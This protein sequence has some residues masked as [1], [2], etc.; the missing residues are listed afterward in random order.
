MNAA[1]LTILLAA[2]PAAAQEA[3]GAAVAEQTL[4]SVHALVMRSSKEALAWSPRAKLYSILG[5]GPKEGVLFEEWTVVYGDPGAKDGFFA[6]KFGDGIMQERHVCRGDH[7][8]REFYW[9]G[10]LRNR[11]E[12]SPVGPEPYTT[13]LPLGSDFM[14]A[15]RL[16]SLLKARKFSRPKGERWSLELSRLTEPK[17]S[18]EFEERFN[19]GFLL[20]GTFRAIGPIPANGRDRIM[21]IVDNQDEAVFL[22]AATGRLINR[23]PTVNKTGGR[24]AW[25]VK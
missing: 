11:L 25:Q 10:K 17:R 3:G 2:L 20:D 12:G 9:D 6:I 15:P 1:A 8:V 16:D 13:N 5:S 7:V 23:R 4:G 14:D 21:W 19:A 22:D 24:D 18:E